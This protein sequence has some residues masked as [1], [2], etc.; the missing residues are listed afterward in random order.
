MEAAEEIHDTAE[1]HK[2]RAPG[3][4]GPHIFALGAICFGVAMIERA[5]YHNS[6]AQHF[7]DS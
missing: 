4:R 2:F 7:E 3:C 5:A 1:V 6:G